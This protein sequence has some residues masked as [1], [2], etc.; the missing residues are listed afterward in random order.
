VSVSSIANIMKLYLKELEN[1][2]VT[3]NQVQGLTQGYFEQYLHHLA[4][5]E[6]WETFMDVLA[7]TLY[8]LCNH[9]RHKSTLP[10]QPRGQEDK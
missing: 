7:L 5:K 4:S 10:F 6:E 3:R 8:V 1:R 9:S 2:L